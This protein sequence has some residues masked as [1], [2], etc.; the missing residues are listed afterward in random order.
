MQTHARA[1]NTRIAIATTKNGA[2]TASEYM[3]KMK[4]VSDEMAAA[5]KPLGDEELMLY[6]LA[7][8]DMEYN[9]LVTSMLA[10]VKPVPYSK[11]LSQI[12]SFENRLEL[13]TPGAGGS[14]SSANTASR[15]GGRGSNN[16]GGNCGRG[17]PGGAWLRQ[18]RT[19]AR[20]QHAQQR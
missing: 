9:P 3:A 6:I 20:L 1:V 10:R 19:W 14:Q 15:N 5:G 2:M 11:L 8:L 12:L 18:W 16:R 17:Q 7:G 13:L 4:T